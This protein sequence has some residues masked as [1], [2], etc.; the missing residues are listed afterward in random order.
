VEGRVAARMVGAVVTLLAIA[1]VIEG[2]L[3]TSDAPAAWKYGVSATTVMLLGLYVASGW[4]YLKELG[5]KGR[6]P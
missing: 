3:S 2:L 1:G 5:P 6:V 4:A